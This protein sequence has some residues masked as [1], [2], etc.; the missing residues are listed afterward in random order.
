MAQQIIELKGNIF[1]VGSGYKLTLNLPKFNYANYTFTKDQITGD[2][3]TL[4]N[5]Y[6]RNKWYSIRYVPH[7]QM[8]L[9]VDLKFIRYEETLDIRKEWKYGKE[10]KKNLSKIA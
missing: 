10:F 9:M 2:G 3:F 8:Y 7:L 5:L 6:R 1:K 4:I